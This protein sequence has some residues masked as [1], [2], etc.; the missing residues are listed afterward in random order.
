MTGTEPQ[1]A[2]TGG[3]KLTATGNLSRAVVDEMCGSIECPNYDKD[4]LFRYQKVVN[5]PDFLPLR[6]SRSTALAV[7][8]DAEI[9]V[10]VRLCSRRM[11]GLLAEGSS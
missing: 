6:R 3:L 4:E 1:A 5:E 7:T 8:A 9:S 2:K 10:A 11:A